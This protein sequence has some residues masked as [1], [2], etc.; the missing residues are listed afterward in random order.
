MSE[1]EGIDDGPR[2]TANLVGH[3]AAETQLLELWNAGR[4]P[5]AVMLTGRPGIGKATLGFRLARFVL[6]SGASQG[7]GGLFED[8]GPT[9]LH[10]APESPTFRR[11]AAGG[12]VDM[13]V[14]Q[15]P[16]DEKKG[17]RRGVIPM[18]M[19]Q[20]AVSFLRLTSGEGGWRV[21]LVDA[22]DDLNVSSA[23][24]LLKVLEEPPPQVLLILL[25][26]APGRVLPT[27]RSRC[28]QIPL[29]PLSEAEALAVVADKSP[30]TSPGERALAVALAEGSPGQALALL[31]QGAAAIYGAYMDLMAALPDYP[32]AKAQT[33][34]DAVGIG[35]DDGPFAAFCDVFNGWLARM[36]RGA[37]EEGGGGTIADE[38]RINARLY[39]SGNLDPWFEVWD[40]AGAW[41]AETNGL[42]LD[43]KQ[44]VLA[45][46]D[47]CAVA[48]R[49]STTA[50]APVGAA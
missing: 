2:M 29:S 3:Q 21:V 38:A 1:P 15:R 39:T 14:L 32:F 20:K 33:F 19:A 47:A 10:V 50:S 30:D 4:M 44:A 37:V 22:V 8:A 7:G 35:T 27:I 11:V 23:N 6:A 9:T 5:H 13:M 34:A 42:N 16:W 17:K 26:N 18:D 12:H 36:L 45:V 43:R 49:H 40:K 41:F 24:A 48:C 25:A 28:R 31:E 46:I